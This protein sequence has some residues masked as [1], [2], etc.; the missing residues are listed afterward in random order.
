MP[1]D[2]T[3]AQARNLEDAFF[4]KE[5]AKLLEKLREKAQREERRAALRVVIRNADDATIDHLL[6]LGIRPETA[7][8]VALVPLAAVAW[9]D[10][11]LDD[12]ERDAILRAAEDRGVHAGTPAREMLE[13]WLAR[14]PGPQLITAWKHYVASVW[15]DLSAHEREDLREAMIGMARRVAEAAGGFL[16]VRS[17]SAA[18]RAVLQDLEATLS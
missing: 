1:K 7:L 17:I 18:E 11:T 15:S 14:A 16:G 8:A 12:R 13:S 10:G 9:A 3:I 5:N 4:A 2:P 6:D